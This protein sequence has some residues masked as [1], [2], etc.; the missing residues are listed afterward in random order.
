[1]KLRILLA[2]LI[3]GL[4]CGVAAF[5]AETGPELFQ[6]AVTQETAAGNLEEAIKLYQRVAKEFASDRALAAKALMAA[7]HC[8]E[9]QGQSKQDR[10]IELYNQVA[11]Q[12]KDQVQ[13]AA[14]ASARLAAIR[15]ANRA[16][17]PVTVTQRKVA[18]LGTRP[19]P[20]TDGR[21]AFYQDGATN[22]LVISDVDGANKHVIYKPKPGEKFQVEVSRDFS[23]VALRLTDAGGKATAVV[24]R[25]DGTGYRELFKGDPYGAGQPDFSW[26][27]RYL[28]YAGVPPGPINDPTLQALV[29]N[30]GSGVVVVSLADGKAREVLRREGSIVEHAVPSPDGRFMAFTEL[31]STGWKTF[32][33][34]LQGGEPRLIPNISR[35]HD[36]TPD[37]R[38]LVASMSRSGNEALYL[39]PIRDGQPG[40]PVFVRSGSFS[41]GV[42]FPNGTMYYRSIRTDATAAV[43]AQLDSSGQLGAWKTLDLNTAGNATIGST[44]WS[45]D[46]A[47]IGYVSRH[48][49]VGQ[50][51]SAFRVH[52]PATGED[53]EVFSSATGTDCRWVAQRPM[54]LCPDTNGGVS[55]VTVDSG[56]V[57]RLGSVSPGDTVVAFARERGLEMV[58]GGF[59]LSATLVRMVNR[60]LEFRPTRDSDWKLLVTLHSER[61]NP[62]EIMYWAK[63]VYYFDTDASGKEGLFRISEEGGAPQRLGD[64]PGSDLS[65]RVIHPSWDG[66]QILVEGVIG[67][68]SAEGWLLEN[69]IPK[70]PAAR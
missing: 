50:T 54:L 66:R 63:A 25:G 30:S 23:M 28:V 65:G 52:N 55:L 18:P 58:R 10:A 34:P 59:L 39:V 64:A 6:K 62:R 37:G 57:E 33:T 4:I 27:N 42:V 17:Q 67:G 49:D 11:R 40:D 46:N 45:P 12:Y 36:W 26:D 3:A 8:Y 69:F 68:L 41:N 60:D 53:R 31:E 15:Q 47:W 1:M 14:A 19:I 2:G 9:L 43:L 56:K 48:D 51:S 20:F 13:P 70:A 5:A 38:F 21:R 7:A 61:P 44:V 16:A 32:V 22:A 29:S 24:I 35:F